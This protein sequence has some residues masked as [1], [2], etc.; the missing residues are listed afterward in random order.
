M[1]S[2]LAATRHTTHLL[3]NGNRRHL[4]LAAKLIAQGEIVP[5]E[6][7]THANCE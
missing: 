3:N 1:P 5:F 6:G 2:E 7:A 4:D